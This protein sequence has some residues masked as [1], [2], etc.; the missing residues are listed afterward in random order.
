M[1]LKVLEGNL[2]HRPLNVNEP[3]PRELVPDRPDKLS[4]EAKQEWDRVVVEMQRSPGWLTAVDMGVLAGYSQSL[5]NWLDLVAEVRKNGWIYEEPDGYGNVK[6]RARPEVALAKF[7]REA[8][9]K[10]AVELGF[11]PG[12]RSRISAAIPNND[13]D[14]DVVES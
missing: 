14:H 6:L 3:K 8:M 5:A 4:D 10:F 9:R 7:E 1:A 13:S 12:S 11:S 2:G